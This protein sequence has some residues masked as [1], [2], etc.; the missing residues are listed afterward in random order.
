MSQR[1]LYAALVVCLA[2]AVVQDAAAQSPSLV[3]FPTS[4]TVTEASSATYT[5][6]LATLPTAAV[7]VSIGGTSGTDLSLNKTS[8][9]FTTSNYN[10]AQTV[11]VRAAGDDDAT[12]DS[13][14]LTHTAA[15]G[16]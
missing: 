1:P 15:G 9:T 13:A 5:V 12:N 10:T 6:K 14:T 2:M 16:G 3:L 7:T 11:T 4:L 8:L